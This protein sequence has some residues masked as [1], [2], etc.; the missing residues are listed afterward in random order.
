MY[1]RCVSVGLKVLFIF[2]ADAVVKVLTRKPFFVIKEL[3]FE[4]VFRAV[5]IG[6]SVGLGPRFTGAL[7]DNRSVVAS[8]KLGFC[9]SSHKHYCHN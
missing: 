9:T 5:R 1:S 3:S 2:S 4:T 8:H 7:N 6:N